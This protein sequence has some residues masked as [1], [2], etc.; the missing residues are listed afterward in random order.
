[1]GKNIST[2]V[3]HLTYGHRVWKPQQVSGAGLVARIYT[4]SNEMNDHRSVDF[5]EPL[6]NFEE[7]KAL[8]I[9]GKNVNF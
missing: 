3:Q 6:H 4:M 7:K 1:M 8:H 9:H 2:T 5:F